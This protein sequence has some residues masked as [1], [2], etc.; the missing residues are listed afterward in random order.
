MKLLYKLF[1]PCL[2][3]GVLF[4]AFVEENTGW[5]YVQSTGQ[6]FYMF[7][8]PMD[9]VDVLGDTIDG[10]GDGSNSQSPDSDCMLNPSLCDVFGAFMTRDLDEVSCS[11]AGGYYVNGQC[12]VC[13]GWSYYNSYGESSNG[14]LV[15]TLS[16]MGYD[17][18]DD[19][20]YYCNDDESPK[21]KYYDVSE[22]I[23]YHLSP[24]IDMGGYANNNIFLYWP[25]CTDMSDCDEVHF[26]ASEDD[27]LS[28]EDETPNP[29]AFE[30]T[31]IYPNPFNPSVSIQYT[32]GSL[33]HI[34]ISIYDTIGRHV[35]TIF[36]GFK[37]T[38]F[39]ELTWTPEAS[40]SSG[41]YIVMIET[42]DN[43]FTRKVTYVK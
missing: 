27:P 6:T 39:H 38:G 31:S 7:V 12:D 26:V 16:V 36:D 10:I 29:E 30:L 15:T 9:I 4:S 20:E 25:D 28:N 5:S 23:V 13:V 40:V 3:M 41:N 11:D 32:I 22:G 18:G 33:E 1:T 43:L 8:S 14:T 21:L 34:N 24:D 19:F 35:T 42:P 37:D 2:F 17:T